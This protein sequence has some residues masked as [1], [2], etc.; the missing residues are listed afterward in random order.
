M[1]AYMLKLETLGPSGLAMLQQLFMLGPTWDGNIVSKEARAQLVRLGFAYHA[2]GWSF[3]T[4]E[5]VIAA[6]EFGRV[7]KNQV[8]RAKASSR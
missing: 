7:S 6:I 1:A 8:Y 4:E 3:L 5:G 2:D